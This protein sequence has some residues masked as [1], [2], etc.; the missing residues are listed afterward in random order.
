[1]SKSVFDKT[2]IIKSNINLSR[3]VT[4]SINPKVTLIRITSY[5]FVK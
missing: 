3:V 4:V 1:M 5:V 2:I